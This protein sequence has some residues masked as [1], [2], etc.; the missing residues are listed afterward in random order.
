MKV[1]IDP[2]HGGWDPGACANGM[3]ECDYVLA[4]GRYL[5]TY[6]ITKGHEVHMTRST[7]HALAAGKSADL[8]ERCKIERTWRPDLFVSL[9][10]N[11]ALA[12][13][14]VG[15]EVWTSPGQTM[16]DVAAEKILESFA[17]AFPQRMIRRDMSDGDGDKESKFRVLTGTDGPAVLVEAGFLTNAAEAEWLRQNQIGI[18]KALAVGIEAFAEREA[19]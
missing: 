18:V 12:T 9:H 4:I 10:C 2:G 5:M 1:L 7:D 8:E 15:F 16:S 13:A 17:A 14:A 3:R 6:L 19:A 11:A